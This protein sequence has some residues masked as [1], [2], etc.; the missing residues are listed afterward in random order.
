MFCDFHSHF[1]NKIEDHLEPLI[2]KTAVENLGF[3]AGD[4]LMPGTANM[5][6]RSLYLNFE[7][8][9]RMYGTSAIADMEE[10]FKNTMDVSR[11]ITEED[12][13]CGFFMRIIQE[14]LRIFA[15]LM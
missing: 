9:V 15:P 12:C 10:D 3:I 5:D 14:V 11:Q 2:Q 7:C 8:G 6:F 1:I 4:C 13:R